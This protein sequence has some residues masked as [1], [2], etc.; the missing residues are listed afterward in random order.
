MWGLFGRKPKRLPRHIAVAG[1]GSKEYAQRAG[2]TFSQAYDLK[3]KNIKDYF[4]ACV[5]LNIP[6]FT[7]H[8]LPLQFEDNPL[9]THL[10]DSL[11]TFIN[12]LKSST[13]IV[14]NKVK[15]TVLGK[16]YDLPGRLVEPIK[17]L[18][19]ATQDND[20]FFLNLCINYDGQQE[21][22]D[23][24]NV[25]A[26]QVQAGKRDPTSIDKNALKENLA[27]SYFVPPDLVVR[28]GS[29]TM[30]SV[31]LWDLPHAKMYLSPKSWQEFTKRDFEK[32]IE[33][34]SF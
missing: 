10:V 19:H 8:L 24:A 14:D 31:L 15:V 32:A 20:S 29:P 18:V 22:V 17:E 4:T 16:W 2:L 33:W 23:A 25:L 21:I 34:W 6:T 9:F 11:I 7:V 13:L 28:M 26:R 1:S 12:E 30:T 27:S 5:E 3:F